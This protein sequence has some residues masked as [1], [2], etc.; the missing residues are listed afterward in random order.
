MDGLLYSESPLGQWLVQ[1]GGRVHPALIWRRG[2]FPSEE[3]W[4]MEGERERGGTDSSRYTHTES[5]GH[6][7]EATRDIDA[8]EKLVVLPYELGIA[9]SLVRKRIVEQR[10]QG[11]INNGGSTSSSSLL[12]LNDRQLMIYYIL[13]HD[14]VLSLLLQNG[15]DDAPTGSSSSSDATMLD[16]LGFLLGHIEY[17]RMMPR[18]EQMLTPLWWTEVEREL[19]K[20]SNL[21]PASDVRE[22]EWKHEHAAFLAALRDISIPGFK[23]EENKY[24]W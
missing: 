4:A 17:I 20:G 19:L 12:S 15:N 5:S 9:P 8:S 23:G 3:A 22:Q 10:Q 24:S 14:D 18:P 13:A 1:R 7:L 11:A 21:G 2:E 16:G 6:R